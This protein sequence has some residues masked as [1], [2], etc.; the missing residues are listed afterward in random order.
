MKNNVFSNALMVFIGVM[1]VIAALQLMGWGRTTESLEPEAFDASTMSQL[2]ESANQQSQGVEEDLVDVI[3]ELPLFTDNRQP[4]VAPET[5]PEDGEIE[6][7]EAAEPLKAKVTSIMILGE[8]RYAMILDQLT[9]EQVTLE[10]G[11]PLPGEQGLWV[12]EN[13][14]PRKVVFNSEGEEPVELELDVFDG[15]L[16]AQAAKS[17]RKN[18]NARRREEPAELTQE[19]DAEKQ[20]NSAEEIRRKI[21]ERRAQMRAN[22]AKGNKDDN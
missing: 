17:N 9:N 10:Q 16:N 4:Y 14:E 18:N 21:A 12:V 13:I 8:T 15:Q 22:A 5:D 11:M 3:A 19:T 20:K 6:V 7:V 2:T 1:M